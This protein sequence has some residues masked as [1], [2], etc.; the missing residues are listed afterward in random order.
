MK[1]TIFYFVGYFLILWLTACQPNKNTDNK[2][3]EQPTKVAIVETNGTYQLTVNG[4]PYQI[5][6]AGINFVDGA[7]FKALA[8][9]GGNTFRTW[10]ID[11]LEAEL[12]SA[13]KYNLMIAV[14][15]DMHKELH[16]FDYS[17]STKE[18]EEQLE[19][20]KKA[21][22]KYKNHPNVLCWVPG[23]ELNLLF[24]EKGGLK[25]V[26]PQV[27]VELA[28]I[29]DYIH[30]V[31]PNHPVTTT[32][33]GITK[34]H[35][36]LALKHCPNL[37]FLGY[38]VYGDLLNIQETVKNTEIKKPYMITE[39]GPKGHWEMPTTD[40]GREI[41]EPSAAKAQGLS[42]R[43]QKG[44][45]E[46][47]DGLLI[48][49]FAFEWG[50][51]Q[52]RTPTWYGMFNKS[53]EATARIDE[54][55]RFWTGN[56]PNNRAPLTDSLLLN[57]QHAVNNIY[58]KPGS[59]SQAQVFVREPDQDSLIYQWVILKEV[60]VRSQGG[61]LEK[62]PDAIEFEIIKDKNGLLEFTTPSQEGDYRLF[63]YV[64]DGKGKVGNA[65][66]PF[67]VKN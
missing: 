65:N 12:D 2:I 46:N 34:T 3:T 16:G 6:G 40:W 45:I 24:D 31:D 51:K 33:A 8:E 17:T 15:F 62:E 67:Y 41:E 58:L 49:T 43:I 66:I 18:A 35:I 11:N 25:L 36:E 48:G 29:V 47:N 28:K 42:E 4:E 14:G 27:Y 37:D 39:F 23:N 60:A 22:N 20:I 5:K 59:K 26:N 53:G 13:K 21:I 64:Y 56:Y 52:E 19:R 30:Q 54:L 32:F 9:A 63:S 57:Q 7:N 10:R 44:I 38:Q 55:A 61:A 50:Q 1:N